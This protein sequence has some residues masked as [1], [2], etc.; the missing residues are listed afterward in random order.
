MGNLRPLIP[1]LHQSSSTRTHL[2]R[3]NGIGKKEFDRPGKGTRIK[4]VLKPDLA[5]K[6][7]TE[8]E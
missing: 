8:H 1:Q 6:E 3:P 4:V 2:F 5:K 7:K